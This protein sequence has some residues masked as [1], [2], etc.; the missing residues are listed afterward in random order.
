MNTKTTTK[1]AAR[2]QNFRTHDIAR[3]TRKLVSAVVQ[4][5][6]VPDII[7]SLD[8][9]LKTFGLVVT[10]HPAFKG[11]SDYGLIISNRELT[12]S[13]LQDESEAQ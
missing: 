11:S 5:D 13:E 4:G 8:H 3:P 7:D 9:A 10:D 12:Q 1:K 6:N 2:S